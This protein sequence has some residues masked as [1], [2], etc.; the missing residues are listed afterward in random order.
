MSIIKVL[1]F[2]SDE[3]NNVV[4][5]TTLV[6]ILVILALIYINKALYEGCDIVTPHS[7]TLSRKA[8]PNQH[9][10]LVC[11]KCGGTGGLPSKTPYDLNSDACNICS[12]R[13]YVWEIIN[14]D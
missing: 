1:V 2:M 11:P 13:G 9:H 8:K 3:Y 12:G 6:A 10:K 7:T 14:E 5:L 4:I